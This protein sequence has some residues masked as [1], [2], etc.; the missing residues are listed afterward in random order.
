MDYLQAIVAQ[1]SRIQISF[2]GIEVR[3]VKEQMGTPTQSIGKVRYS[4][5]R[6]ILTE[7]SFIQDCLVESCRATILR[8][9]TIY[10]SYVYSGS[11]LHYTPISYDLFNA[12]IVIQCFAVL[13]RPQKKELELHCPAIVKFLKIITGQEEHVDILALFLFTLRTFNYMDK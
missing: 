8:T 12:V 7:N 3:Q 9:R 2:A 10:R 6:Q 11:M 5:Y 4:R 13:Q 1:F